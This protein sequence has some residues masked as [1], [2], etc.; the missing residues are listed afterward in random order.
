MHHLVLTLSAQHMFLIYEQNFLLPPSHLPVL[1]YGENVSLVSNRTSRICKINSTMNVLVS[2]WRYLL[3]LWISVY[4]AA[5]QKRYL[6]KP[7]KRLRLLSRPPSCLRAQQRRIPKENHIRM[8]Y[9]EPTCRQSSMVL[10][11][12]LYITVC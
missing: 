3:Y 9:R 1:I 8:P 2:G 12:S 11:V 4:S 7:A 5:E 10:A 6:Y